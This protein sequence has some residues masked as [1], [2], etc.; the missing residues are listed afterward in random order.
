MKPRTTLMLVVVLGVLCLGYW[1]ML[2]ME[3]RG[4]EKAVE[5][6]QLF[7]FTAEALTGLE[8]ARLGEE[9]VA[10]SRVPGGPWRVT[11]PYDTIPA[12]PVVWP[13]VAAALA[14]LSNQRSL[15]VADADLEI[16]G[17][18]EPVLTIR[19][20]TDGGH[21]VRVAFGAAEPTQLNRYARMLEGGP[22]GVFLAPVAAFDE[23]NRPLIDLRERHIVSVGEAG[24]TRLEFAL[25]WRG[26]GTS[27]PAEGGADLEEGFES[28]A[29]VVERGQDG[30]WH[31]VAPVEGIAN[32]QLVGD[33]V[34]E[35]QFAV[36]RNHVDA[37]ENLADYG[38]D[39]PVARVSVS[40]GV[41]AP[42]TI[43][44]GSL[45]E[46]DSK[47]GLF[48][49]R[50]DQPAVFIMDSHVVSLF[51]QSVDSFRE[52][53]LLTHRV[54]EVRRVH[55]RTADVDIVLDND[56]ED[57]W[58]VVEPACD[59]TDQQA[60]SAFITALKVLTATA[61]V[62]AESAAAM[63]LGLDTPSM[64]FTLTFDGDGTPVEILVGGATEDGEAFYAKQDTGAVVTVPRRAIRDLTWTLFD[65][66][67]RRLLRF[68]P[69]DA[70]RVSLQLEERRYLFEKVHRKWLIREPKGARLDSQSDV[71]AVLNA[72]AS[73]NAL[74]IEAESAP[75]DLS[76]YGLAEPMFRVAVT[77]CAAEGA[78]RT[79][80]DE[81]VLG[82]LE[83]GNTTPDDARRRYALTRGYREV[84]VVTQD[85][86]DNVR[87]AL[88]GIG[89]P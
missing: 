17:L 85:I 58:R 2:R 6:K 49:K 10:A 63:A 79:P 66:R 82:P 88:E 57:G 18:D 25:F 30:A 44:F 7:D 60:V 29:V 77:T 39:P 84:F 87:S 50:A 36:G 1:L 3:D 45:S 38:L 59:D 74:G 47:G 19:G 35:I 75:G 20:E 12:N 51:P 76:P 55:Y 89:V 43:L 83:I 78:A 48:A 4:R 28:V 62:D 72:V 15:D 24:I 71:E 21:R 68:A 23:L 5:A 31:M 73:V 9:P 34:K 42:Q 46:G 22:E 54:T 26:E 41:G 11:A 67:S 70:I 69:E 64:V 80:E 40:D 8:V 53:R 33:L 52:S 56:P 81:V 14:G 61:F 65:F 13:R 37:P 32:Q 27:G 86:L 16:Y